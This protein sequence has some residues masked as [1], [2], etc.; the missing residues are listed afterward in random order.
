MEKKYAGFNEALD[1]VRE[2]I[3]DML[4]IGLKGAW[5]QPEDSTPAPDEK[6]CFPAMG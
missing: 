6:M 4:Y 1:A 3:G 5:Q 2:L